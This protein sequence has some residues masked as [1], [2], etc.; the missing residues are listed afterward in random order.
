MVTMTSGFA[1]MDG[2]AGFGAF[3][4][5]PQPASNMKTLVAARKARMLVIVARDQVEGRLACEAKRQSR[6]YRDHLLS[7]LLDSLRFWVLAPW[8]TRRPRAARSQGSIAPG[9]GVNSG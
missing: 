5:D 8:A 6:S 4:E 9:I 1:A 3:V 7:P 2:E